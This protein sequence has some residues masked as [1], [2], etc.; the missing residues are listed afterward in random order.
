MGQQAW[1]CSYFVCDFFGE[2][3]GFCSYEIV[4]IKKQGKEYG[5]YVQTI[6]WRGSDIL[7]PCKYETLEKI[8]YVVFYTVFN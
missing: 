2:N 8:G 6:V 4:L 7:F 1:L 3:Q 5:C